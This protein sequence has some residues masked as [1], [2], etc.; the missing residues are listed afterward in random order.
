MRKITTME[1]LR[2]LRMNFGVRIPRRERNQETMGSSKTTP[3]ASITL[4]MKLMYSLMA[5]LFSMFREPKP[6]KN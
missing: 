6:A 4:M 2:Y 1:C 5:M 3:A